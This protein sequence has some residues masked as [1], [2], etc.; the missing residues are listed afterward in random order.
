ML[1]ISFSNPTHTTTVLYGRA[2][3]DCFYFVLVEQVKR[4]GDSDSDEEDEKEEIDKCTIC[5]S[6][7]V[8]DEDVRYVVFSKCLPKAPQFSSNTRAT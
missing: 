8:E 5:L 1:I 2:L 6:E 7:F 3:I 4:V